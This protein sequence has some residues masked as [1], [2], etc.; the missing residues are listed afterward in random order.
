MR[1]SPKSGSRITWYLGKW[2]GVKLRGTIHAD[3]P[4]G[5]RP[6]RSSWTGRGS[7][8]GAGGRP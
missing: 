1:F 2:D 6:A 4:T 5:R 7:A 8:P 3:T